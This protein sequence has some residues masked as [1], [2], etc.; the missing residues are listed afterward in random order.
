MDSPS[1]SP[2]GKQINEALAHMSALQTFNLELFPAISIPA[3]GQIPNGTATTL[4]TLKELNLDSCDMDMCD[5]SRTLLNMTSVTSLAP[6]DINLYKSF[7]DDLAQA[8]LGLANGPCELEIFTLSFGGIFMGELE[9]IIIPSS[10]HKPV[11]LPLESQECHQAVYWKHAVRVR[12][13][14]SLQAL[15]SMGRNWAT[16]SR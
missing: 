12:A 14:A 5:F 4:L 7:K 6:S 11:L 3:W 2:L 16:T 10:L 15:I 13:Y 1:G 9:E 8:F